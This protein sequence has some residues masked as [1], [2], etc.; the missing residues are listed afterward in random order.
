LTA[1]FHPPTAFP[2][3][4]SSTTTLLKVTCAKEQHCTD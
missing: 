3:Q 1:F 4:S 2:R